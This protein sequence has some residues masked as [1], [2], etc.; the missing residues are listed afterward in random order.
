L[1]TVEQEVY[2]IC[3][4][5]GL[6][7]RV[8]HCWCKSGPKGTLIQQYSTRQKGRNE[9]PS[10]DYSFFLHYYYLYYYCSYLIYFYFY[11]AGSKEDSKT[12]YLGTLLPFNTCPMNYNDPPIYR[13]GGRRRFSPKPLVVIFFR[14]PGGRGIYKKPLEL[15]Q[16]PTNPYMGWATPPTVAPQLLRFGWHNKME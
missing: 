1:I 12:Q 9:T 4:P 15:T 16:R 11:K 10:K 5:K 3:N 2:N 13:D 7:E 8:C 6:T 14:A